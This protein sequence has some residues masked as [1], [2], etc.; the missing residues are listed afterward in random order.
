MRGVRPL[1]AA[2]LEEP[3]APTALEQFVQQQGFRAAGEQAVPKLA[4]HGKIEPGM[5]SL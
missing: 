2:R 1:L 3:E 5:V 4:E